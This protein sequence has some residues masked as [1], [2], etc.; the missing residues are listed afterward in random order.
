VECILLTLVLGVSIWAILSSAMGISRLGTFSREELK[1]HSVT[2][3]LFE[4]LEAMHPASF[5]VDFAGTVQKAISNMGGNGNFL[6]G[7]RVLVDNIASGNGVRL[8]QVTLSTPPG[9]KKAP[10]VARKS[11]SSLSEKTVDDAI[12]IMEKP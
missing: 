5:D 1:A 11:L 10:F 2:T 4:T 12:D 3:G 6:R 7:Y 9:S 8:V